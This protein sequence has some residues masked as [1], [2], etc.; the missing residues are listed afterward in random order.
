M[1]HGGF[2]ISV[3]H[4]EHTSV[5]ECAGDLDLMPAEKLRE[6]FEACLDGAPDRVVLDCSGVTLLSSAGITALVDTAIGCRERDIP[7]DLRLS[8]HARKVLDLV[9]L[10]WLGVVHDGISI[11]SA[12]QKALRAYAEE[13]FAGNL[14]D[15]DGGS[16]GRDLERPTTP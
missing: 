8:P 4:R 13:K 7:L 14:D 2:S 5:I 11:H 16:G 6:T 3:H 10:W 1:D 15:L 12:L 9:G